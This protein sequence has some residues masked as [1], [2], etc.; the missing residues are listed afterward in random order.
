MSLIRWLRD[1]L[2][3]PEPERLPLDAQVAA[4]AAA[5]QTGRPNTWYIVRVYAY[6]HQVSYQAALD[7]LRGLDF[8]QAKVEVGEA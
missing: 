7:A 6:Q 1:L 2:G 4:L 3:P 5:W 8:D